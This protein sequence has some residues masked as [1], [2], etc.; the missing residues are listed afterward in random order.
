MSPVPAGSVTG[1]NVAVCSLDGKF[2]SG[3]LVNRDAIQETKPNW[4][5]VCDYCTAL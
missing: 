1:T 5:I 4:G 2:L 3:S